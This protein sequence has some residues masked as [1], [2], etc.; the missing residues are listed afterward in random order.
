MTAIEKRKLER[1]LGMG[2]GYVLGFS[3]RTFAEFFHDSIG[4]DIYDTKYDYGSGSKANRMR[5]FW[6]RESNYSVGKVLG[7]LF[8]EWDEFK[9][10]D[11]PPEPPEECLSIASRLQGCAPVADIGAVAANLNDE[12]FET[13]AR[14]VRECID[15]NEP[16]TGLDRLHTFLVKYFRAL[17]A[18]RGIGISLEKPLHSLVGEYVK[19]LKNEGL[20]ESDMTERILKSTISVMEAFNRVRNEQSF[21][22]DNRV[23]NYN[24]SLLIFS[25]VT[26]SIKFIEAIEMKMA[27]ESMVKPDKDDEVPFR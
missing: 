9:G 22:H 3:N 8:K 11:S 20:I 12:G 18:R 1:A 24:E 4:I 13:L 23:L 19:T 5:A 16:E 17:C 15:R 21:A 27:T 14:S 10:Y 25:H 26:S 7:L 6:E 2:G